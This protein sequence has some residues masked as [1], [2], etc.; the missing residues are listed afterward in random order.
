VY[1]YCLFFGYP[2][3]GYNIPLFK[4]TIK[5]EHT[6]ERTEQG[7]KTTFYVCLNPRKPNTFTFSPPAES[8]WLGWYAA[9]HQY[10]GFLRWAFCS[11]NSDP[12]MSTDYSSW[13]T[14]D[15]F[16]IYPGPRSSIR[17]E[18]LREGIQDFEKIRVLR[19]AFEKQG[20]DG[21]AHLAR[22]DAILQTIERTNHV[23]D[24]HTN[25]VNKAK[26]ALAELSLEAQP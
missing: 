21:K 12:F 22:L 23:N 26:K 13:P 4:S 10:S 18:R 20:E 9:C 5:R 14:G 2:E 8:T 16:L 25:V 19:E 6:A 15:G 1:D 7:K 24:D 17:F 3:A 11:Y